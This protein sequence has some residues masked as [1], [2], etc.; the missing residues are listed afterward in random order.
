MEDRCTSFAGIL[1]A[2][3]R[4]PLQ[5]RVGSPGP[6]AIQFKRDMLQLFVAQGYLVEVRKLLLIALP[7]GDWRQHQIEYYDNKA[8]PVGV[9]EEVWKDALCK[10]LIG[11][12]MCA[13]VSTSPPMY[14]RHRWT[15]AD[16]ACDFLGIM[17]A[18]HCLLSSTMRRFALAHLSPARQLAVIGQLDARR[19]Q[20]LVGLVEDL[21]QI[22]DA[23][24]PEGGRREVPHEIIANKIR[25]SSC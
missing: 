8:R 14:P 1:A 10:R 15:G 11:G 12:L 23:A 4:I 5:L 21:P 3:I 16:L 6:D 19:Q 9:S 20:F 2:E 17:E 7:N 25:G 18:C 13:L 22:E 24:P